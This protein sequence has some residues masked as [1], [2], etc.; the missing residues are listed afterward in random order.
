[1]SI[2]KRI[3]TATLLTS[4]VFVAEAQF[5]VNAK[6]VNSATK[7]VKATTL[8][9][10]EVID[11]VKEYIDWMDTNNS[12]ASADDEL[13]VRLQRLNKGLKNYD[14]DELNFIV[15]LVFD[16]NAFACAD[17]SVRV[18]A[19]LMQV[20]TDNEV[21]GVIGHVKNQDSRDAFRTALLTSALKD[22]ISSLGGA[23][24]TLSDFST[25]SSG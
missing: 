14:G 11:Y 24:A 6:V 4:C 9:N 17:G 20:M 2:C 19:G 12:V 3:L 15:Y 18:C 8:S 1:M 16:I 21:L 7:V 25:R 5:K 13:N 22:G 23:A 10:E